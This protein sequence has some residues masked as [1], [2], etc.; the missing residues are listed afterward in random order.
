[1]SPYIKLLYILIAIAV[2]Y[3]IYSLYSLAMDSPHRISSE[4]ARKRLAKREVD[5][6]LDVRTSA[7][8]NTLGF[9]PRSLHMPSDRLVK[10]F[11]DALS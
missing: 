1:M 10:D 6:V 11:P 9:F 5:V 3:I 8:R 4:E 7:E 2:I